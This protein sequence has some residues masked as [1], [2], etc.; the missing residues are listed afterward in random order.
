MEDSMGLFEKIQEAI[1]D[2]FGYIL[3]GAIVIFFIAPSFLIYNDSGKIVLPVQT[4]FYYGDLKVINN[5]LNTNYLNTRGVFL[6]ILAWIIGHLIR[7]ISILLYK[8]LTFVC[9]KIITNDTVKLSDNKIF[10]NDYMKKAFDIYKLEFPYTDLQENKG[11]IESRLA[12][13][14]R[15]E[16]RMSNTT[17]LIQKYIAKYNLYASLASICILMDLTVLIIL[18]LKIRLIAVVIILAY[19]V[20]VFL[21]LMLIIKN[22]KIKNVKSLINT[23]YILLLSSI[24]PMFLLVLFDKNLIGYLS[25]Y[26]LATFL[27]VVFDYEGRRHYSL[28]VKE[29]IYGIIA[30]N[31]KSKK[32]EVTASK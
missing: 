20:V 23:N 14:G 1:Y 5:I 4:F 10:N 31:K 6:L 7:G 3:P 17:S 25:I 30:S 2:L 22:K 18:I 15:M 26:C 24:L 9:K 13:Y 19:S 12:S 27:F 8:T 16:M 11:E 28:G 29:S 32:A 21:V